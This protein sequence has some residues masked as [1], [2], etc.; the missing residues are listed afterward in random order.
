[1]NS[2]NIAILFVAIHLC[3]SIDIFYDTMDNAV[4]TGWSFSGSNYLAPTNDDYCPNGGYCTFIYVP[5]NM[6][7]TFINIDQYISFQIKYDLRYHTYFTIGVRYKYNNHA[8]YIILLE[9]STTQSSPP[10]KLS[11][12]THTLGAPTGATSVT[13]EFYGYGYIDNFYFIGSTATPTKNPTLSPTPT[14]TTSPSSPPTHTPT[15][16]PTT[17]PTFLPTN[18]PTNY[19]TIYPTGSPSSPPTSVPSI[20]PTLFPSGSPSSPPTRV[21]TNNPT[22]SPTR[23]PTKITKTPTTIPTFSPSSAPSV[24]PTTPPSN[25]P[26]FLPSNFPSLSPTNY[27]SNVPSIPP[28]FSPTFIDGFEYGICLDLINHIDILY[29]ITQFECINYCKETNDCRMINHYK[30]FKTDDDSR[31]YI[32]NSSCKLSYYLNSNPSS[33][34]WFKEI[35]N[36]YD[37]TCSDYPSNWKDITGD[38]CYIYEQIGWCSNNAISDSHT[39]NDFD[40]L[41]DNVYGLNAAD[42]CCQ[43]SCHGG[44]YTL[45]NNINFVYEN[46]EFNDK[47]LC[48]WQQQQYSHQ[49]WQNWDNLI[50]YEW[51]IDIQTRFDLM[52]KFSCNYL[53]DSEYALNDFDGID[54]NLCD[55]NLNANEY[56]DT[57]YFMLLLTLNEDSNI[58]STYINT[59]WFD[60]NSELFSLSINVVGAVSYESCTSQIYNNDSD[61][62]NETIYGIY[63]CLVLDTNNPTKT[64]TFDPTVNPTHEPTV[65]PTVQPTDNPTI[66]P[67]VNPTNK[68]TS[69]PTLDPTTHPTVDPTH[70]PTVDPTVYPTM[71]PTVNPTSHPS[72]DPTTVP[73]V[74]PTTGP[75]THPTYNPTL[76]PTRNPSRK[77][78]YNHTA[79]PTVKQTISE[80]EDAIVIVDLSNEEMMTTLLILVAILIIAVICV[81]V[82]CVIYSRKV[83]ADHTRQQTQIEQLQVELEKIHTSNATAVER[84]IKGQSTNQQ[85][86]LFGFT[87]VMSTTP[88]ETPIPSAPEQ[89]EESFDLPEISQWTKQNILVWINNIGLQDQWKQIAINAVE[90]GEYKGDDLM[91]LK[92]GKDIAKLFGIQNPMLCNR[93]WRELKK[94]K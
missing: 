63:P 94:K 74:D 31:C 69:M 90:S 19:P 22:K 82:I 17:T 26:S 91:S 16:A 42:V 73:T 57:Y 21:P 38:S 62:I 56:N 79:N 32:F 25:A 51:C 6:Y 23:N 61:N 11:S 66:D 30:Y 70:D 33:I 54:I 64:P 8:N 47:V 50:L 67:T 4:V 37:S 87:T 78:T 49:Q 36:G 58:L 39:L 80:T 68:P 59:K 65:E 20:S 10:Y 41:K 84:S 93:L 52:D 89:Q 2:I 13:F 24:A 15:L 92:S 1:M 14:P 76:E 7:R 75:T 43:C 35:L 48:H 88:I 9:Y 44:L 34:V 18:Y 71:Y 72:K 60:I 83:K 5:T 86:N 46:H 28:T 55:F 85:T 81:I 3:K 45:N 77:P 53:I 40:V 29:D 12:K 27:P